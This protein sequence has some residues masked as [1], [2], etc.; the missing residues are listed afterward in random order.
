MVVQWKLSCVALYVHAV[1]S[2]AQK[3]LWVFVLGKLLVGL[4][5]N[6]KL[7]VVNLNCDDIFIMFKANTQQGGD[8]FIG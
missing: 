6:L 8:W 2:P 5:K 1:Y 3:V 7:S 4:K